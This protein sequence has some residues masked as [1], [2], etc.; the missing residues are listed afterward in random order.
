MRV[1]VAVSGLRHLDQVARHLQRTGELGT[2]Y[3]AHR[4]STG[5]RALGVPRA[6]LVNVWPKAYIGF[7]YERL[8]GTR[9]HLAGRE[10]YDLLWDVAVARRWRDCDLAHLVLQ[11][12]F[13]AVLEAARRQ[14]ARLLGEVLNSHPLV[15]Q[16]L[17]DEERDRLGLPKPA[18]RSGTDRQVTALAPLFDHLLAPSEVVKRS[19]V[20]Q[21]H[22][23][24]RITVVP[25]GIDT[26][27]F[28]PPERTG[29]DPDDRRFRVLCVGQISPRKGQL[30]LLEAWKRLRLPNAELVLIGGIDDDMHRLLAPYAGLF[31]HLGQVDNREIY[32]HYGRASV[33]V[34]PA[35]ED[36]FAYV[37]TEALAC[38]V[39]VITTENTGAGEL[40]REGE[41]GFVVPVRDVD[42]LAATLELLHRDPERRRAL[43]GAALAAA[44]RMTWTAYGERLRSLYRRVL[45]AEQAAA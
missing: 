38:G 37:V 36:A 7:G 19:F 44:R 12:K 1:N 34:L 13:R 30:Y 15:M 45:A 10:V 35:L 23:P 8:L 14:G 17:L 27:R 21:G 39:P 43:G 6:Q 20:E 42:A 40:L 2:F 31:R 25:F 3:Y 4:R 18:V 11:G 29:A 9:F 24:G 26:T 32:R 33:C 16:R 28:H 22:D 5:A 41:T